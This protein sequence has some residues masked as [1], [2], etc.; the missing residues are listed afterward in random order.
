MEQVHQLE[1]AAV[2]VADDV[3]RPGL[4]PAHSPRFGIV[5]TVVVPE[6]FLSAAMTLLAAMFLSAAVTLLGAVRAAM[7]PLP[8]TTLSEAMFLVP[9]IALLGATVPAIRFL[10]RRP[11]IG[12]SVLGS[13]Q[14]LVDVRH[15]PVPLVRPHGGLRAP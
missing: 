10:Q 14:R 12:R 2:D 8:V 1:K 9:I 5:A 6:T 3:K 4:A 13:L 11:G 15:L 7:F